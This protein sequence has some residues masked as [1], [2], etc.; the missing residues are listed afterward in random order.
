MPDDAVAAIGACRC[1]RLDRALEAVEGMS[2][3]R[4]DDLEGQIVVVAT[5]FAGRADGQIPPELEQIP[6]APS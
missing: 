4:G 2:L 6:D 3:T 5:D 1:Q